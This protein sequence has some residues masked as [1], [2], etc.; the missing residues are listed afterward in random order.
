MMSRFCASSE[1]LW[2]GLCLPQSAGFFCF[3]LLSKKWQNVYVALHKHK[4]AILL[5]IFLLQIITSCQIMN[6]K[7]A[8]VRSVYKFSSDSQPNTS[9]THTPPNTRH[10]PQECWGPLFQS[11]QT[12]SQRK[13]IYTSTWGCNHHRCTKQ[14]RSN[15]SRHRRETSQHN[16]LHCSLSTS[17]WTGLHIQIVPSRATAASPSSSYSSSI[18]H[19]DQVYFTAPL[20]YSTSIHIRF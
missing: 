13:N 10:K 1:S 2:F 17:V 7:N 14:L 3:V 6:L 19:R 12:I 8:L 5:N 4:R 20:H 16:L 9:S 18:T 15:C 11:W